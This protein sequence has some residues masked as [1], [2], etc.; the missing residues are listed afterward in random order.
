[1][2][3]RTTRQTVFLYDYSY[4]YIITRISI[5]LL[6]F[7][8]YYWYFYSITRIS[9]LFDCKLDSQHKNI[10]SKSSKFG[11]NFNPTHDLT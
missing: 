2:Q 3:T 11:K 7:L 6:V 9:I 8:Y 4:F 10:D 5:L 1:M